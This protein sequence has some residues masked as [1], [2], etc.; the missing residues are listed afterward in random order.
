MTRRDTCYLV[1]R[2][3]AGLT[4]REA[5]AAWWDLACRLE[6]MGEMDLPKFRHL[7][8]QIR[9]ATITGKQQK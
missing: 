1:G 5:A 8:K 4:T 7:L 6:A 9:L 3:A 2:R